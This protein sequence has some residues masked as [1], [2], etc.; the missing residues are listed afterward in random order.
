MKNVLVTG[1]SRGLGLAITTH[2]LEADPEY[3]VYAVS[4]TLSDG[5]SKL[6]AEYPD[7]LHHCSVDLSEPE[8]VKDS[9]FGKDFIGFDVKL[10]GIV[11]NAALAYDDLSTNMKLEPLEEMFRVNVFA[12]MMLSKYAIRNMVFHK[13]A[14]SLV[15]ISSISTQT[16]F[17]GLSMYA[18]T[19]GAMEAYSKNLAREWGSTGIR[20]NCVS[21]GF[22]KT[23]MSAS[24][25]DE[26]LEKIFRRTA[27]KQATSLESVAATVA[28][29]L[30]DAS[31]SVTGQ[32]I[33]VDA[34]AV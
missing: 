21:P 29:L 33:H 15:H 13:T 26:Q 17:K 24:V 22:M 11:N 20:S 4:R 34:G 18:S 25:T 12:G 2:L 5:L 19:K 23:D 6:K 1:A 30:S 32:N 8:K 9:V 10:H 7:R 27:M 3:V 31:A 16:G 28:Y 14:G